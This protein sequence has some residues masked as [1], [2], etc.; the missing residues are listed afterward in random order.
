MTGR[1]RSPR[2]GKGAARCVGRE[3]RCVPLRLGGAVNVFRASATTLTCSQTVTAPGVPA[4][5]PA[6]ESPC[7]AI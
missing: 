2:C 3:C 5:R 4:R 1:V 7:G 6:V